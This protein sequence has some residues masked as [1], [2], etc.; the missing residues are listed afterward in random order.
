M[1]TLILQADTQNLPVMPT[2]DKQSHKLAGPHALH[3]K[4]KG[5]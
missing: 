1:S 5:Y 3:H 4:L 2:E